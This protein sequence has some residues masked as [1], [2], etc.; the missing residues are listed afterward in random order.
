MARDPLAPFRY[1][2]R[3]R[4]QL[5]AAYQGKEVDGLLL[6]HQRDLT[7]LTGKT[8]EVVTRS[9]FLDQQLEPMG[10]FSVNGQSTL[11]ADDHD[12]RFR[13]FEERRFSKE[14]VLTGRILAYDADPEN[15]IGHFMFDLLFSGDLATVMIET[16]ALYRG[17]KLRVLVEPDQENG[18]ASWRKV[19]ATVR[20]ATAEAT[21]ACEPWGFTRAAELKGVTFSGK[22]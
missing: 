12:G 10:P 15:K 8:I 1:R 13:Q 4:L 17:T 7:V 18:R 11:A 6:S 14:L 21:V 3:V 16:P 9:K 5:P 20:F 22:E 19:G 2:G